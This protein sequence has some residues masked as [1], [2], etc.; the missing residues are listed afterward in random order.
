VSR[1]LS[2]L[3]FSN[4][5][6]RAGAEEHILTLLHGLDRQLFRAHLVCMP[7]VAAQVRRDLPGDVELTVLRLRRPRQV[8]AAL[9]L[10]RL[11][12][13]QRIDILHSHLFYASLFASPIGWLC[14]VP[15][16]IETPH[17]REHWRH[18]WLKGRFFVDRLVGRCVDRYIA[19]S[20][21]NARYLVEQK[22][23]P[24][25]KIVTIHNGCDVDRFD[26]QHAAPTTLRASLGFG[27]QDHILVIVA[28]LEPQKG[29]RVLL[30]ALP[31]VFRHFPHA[32]LVCVGEG[33]LRPALE[34]QARALGVMA[35]VQ[36]VGQQANI[37][38]WLAL[39]DLTVLPSFWEGLPLAAIESLAAGRPVVATGVDGTPEAVVDGRTGLTVPPGEPAPLA[40]A[41]CRLLG[42]PTERQRLGQAGRAWVVEHFT[43]QRQV[44]ETQDLY[45]AAFDRHAR[46][47]EP[48]P[49]AV[50]TT[51]PSAAAVVRP[52]LTP[53]D[54]R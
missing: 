38:D 21:A 32:R 37:A 14:R 9:R 13:A 33:S 19:V 49:G 26:P 6:V 30:T 18:G 36:F 15:V 50:S 7:E 43:Q 41:I 24:A 3:Y 20:E 42:D 29:H 22:G 25:A 1:R 2:I 17:L 10:G 11:L 39:A 44:R 4:S 52:S 35:A 51:A 45:L 53:P 16:I 47:R 28:R 48:A 27:A 34:D 46:L 8:G 54:R 12:R 5:L 40:R 31:E 23:L